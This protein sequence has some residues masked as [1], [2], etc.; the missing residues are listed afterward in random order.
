MLIRNFNER[1]GPAKTR[2]FW[3]QKV[4]KILE[5]KNEGGLFYAVQKESNPHAQ[6]RVLHHNNLLLCQEF[7]G[8][9]NT[10]IQAEI[11]SK[12]ALTRE[13]KRKEHQRLSSYLEIM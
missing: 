3:E 6:V 10:N 13:A 7:Q 12:S 1:G 9:E 2:T 11:P 4:H 8:V 5:K